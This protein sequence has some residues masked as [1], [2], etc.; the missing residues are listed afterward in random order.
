[1][2]PR[3]FWGGI[4]VL[5]LVAVGLYIAQLKIDYDYEKARENLPII[6]ETPVEVHSLSEQESDFSF[7]EKNNYNKSSSR[8][9]QLRVFDPNTVT[10]EQ[11]EDMGMPPRL[12]K[13]ISN[14]RSKGGRFYKKEDIM[15]LYAFREEWYEEYAP[16]ISIATSQNNTTYTKKEYPKNEYKKR[17]SKI[18]DPLNI[19]TC[20][21]EQLD[22]EWGVSPKVAAN[23][24]KFRD[25]LGGFQSIDQ[26]SEVYT[27]PDSVLRHNTN[28]YVQGG[29]QK[30]NINTADY[31]TLNKHPYIRKAKITK[32]LLGYRKSHGEFKSIQD[33]L[34]I[35]NINEET[36]QKIAPYITVN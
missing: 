24:V 33:L 22:A 1:M 5:V 18:R 29:V 11:M 10:T 6:T 25:M 9:L 14:Y 4:I 36:L 26:L 27:L 32:S 30:I 15:K 28:W 21:A 2:N 7:K 31:K 20:T 16:Y 19:N 12:I 17:K 23:I 8:R 3:E 34:K 35:K 13:T